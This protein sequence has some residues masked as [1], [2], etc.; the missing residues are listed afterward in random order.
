MQGCFPA[1]RPRSMG[2]EFTIIPRGTNFVKS[3]CENFYFFIFPKSVD[4]VGVWWYNKYVPRERNSK[5][6]EKKF[7]KVF[8][9]VL[10]NSTEYGIIKIQKG[11]GSQEPKEKNFKKFQKTS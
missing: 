7:Q 4:I 3:F 6:S 10:T 8:K 5:R 9:K 11:K 1:R 2:A